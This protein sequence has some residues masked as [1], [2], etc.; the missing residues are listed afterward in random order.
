MNI[1][2]ELIEIGPARPDSHEIAW[3]LIYD[4]DPGLFDYYFSSDR[5]LMGSCLSSWWQRPEKWEWKSWPQRGCHILKK[6]T[7]SPCIIG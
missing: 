4:T 2:A 7:A 3:K 5:E 1:T 6:I